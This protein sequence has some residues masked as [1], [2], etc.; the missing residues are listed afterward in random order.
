MLRRTMRCACSTPSRK[1]WACRPSA[2][3][4]GDQAYCEERLQ[5]P[6]RRSVLDET[7]ARARRDEE[8]L[9]ARAGQAAL[10]EALGGVD[11]R[12]LDRARGPA[13]GGL[14]LVGRVHGRL[15]EVAHDRA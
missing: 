6:A 10:D 4:D 1:A 2:D 12:V 8:W 15:S 9:A 13:E 3:R 7:A 5:W 14:C 11:D